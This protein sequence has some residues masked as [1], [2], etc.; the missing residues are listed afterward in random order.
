MKH[1]EKQPV[2]DND[3]GSPSQSTMEPHPSMPIHDA[4]T[5]SS[6]GFDHPHHQPDFSHQTTK[7]KLPMFSSNDP[8]GW[9]TRAETYFDIHNIPKNHRIPLAHICMDGVAVHW[10][11]LVRE[12]QNNL[13]WDR[14]RTELLN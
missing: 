12:L 13:S 10:L 9:L 4:S 7:V 3:R 1:T 5:E 14:F 2:V 6:P 8:R 11:S